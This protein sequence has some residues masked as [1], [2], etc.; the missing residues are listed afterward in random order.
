LIKQTENNKTI[1]IGIGSNRNYIQLKKGE[2][3]KSYKW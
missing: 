1:S 3:N 2:A